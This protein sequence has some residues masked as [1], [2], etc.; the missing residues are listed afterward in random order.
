MAGV[1]SMYPQFGI[2]Q[3]RSQQGQGWTELIDWIKTLPISDPH[4]MAFTL[5][6][7]RLQRAAHLDGF[8][9]RDD[10]LCAVCAAEVV[11]SFDGSQQELLN[12]YQ[13]H[14]DEVTS[15]LRKMSYCRPLRGRVHVA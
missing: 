9:C 13:T 1:V 12:L 8:L 2:D 10:P 15:T 11:A 5:T 7:R 6:L 14:V 4:V 3:V